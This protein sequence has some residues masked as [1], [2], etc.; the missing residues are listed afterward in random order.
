MH[1][2]KLVSATYNNIVSGTPGLSSNERVTMAQI[3]DAIINERLSIIKEYM[4]KNIIPYKDLMLS[5]RCLE[6]D[7]ENVSKCCGKDF[8]VRTQ[9]TEIPQIFNDYGEGSIDFIGSTDNEESF[10]VYTDNSYKNHKYRRRGS[11]KPYVWVDTTPNKNGKYDVY[12]FNAPL[13]KKLN[14]RAIFKDPRQLSM[15]S[16]CSSDEF[17]NISFVERELEKRVTENYLRYY[18][19]F[20]LQMTPNTQ[21]P[22]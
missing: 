16:C 4:A 22:K 14:I 20:A 10:T 3:E 12:I 5:I 1:L 17:N 21:Q 19:Q 7:C 2:E 9:H 18:R 6:V 8:G 13:L 11:D 15:Y